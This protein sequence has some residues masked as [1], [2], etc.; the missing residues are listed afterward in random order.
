LR[1]STGK[2]ET[3]FRWMEE[4]ARKNGIELKRLSDRE[5]DDLWNRAKEAVRP[6]S[7]SD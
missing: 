1:L 5:L 3:R 4:E 2:F 6:R 7:S